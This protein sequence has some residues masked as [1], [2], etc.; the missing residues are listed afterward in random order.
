MADPTEVVGVL[1]VHMD[2]LREALDWYRGLTGA[3]DLA[4]SYRQGKMTVRPSRGSMMAQKA[5]NTCDM[6]LRV[7]GEED[8]EQ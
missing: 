6:Y 7:E 8:D 5:I 2:E 3:L 1:R 4:D